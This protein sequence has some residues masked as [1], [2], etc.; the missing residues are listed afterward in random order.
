MKRTCALATAETMA[1]TRDEQHRYGQHYT[2]GDVARLL[3]AFA[4]RAAA[5]LVFDPACGDG[6]LLA[7]AINVKRQLAVQAP[8]EC[9]ARAVLGLDRSAHA[10]ALAAA[11][12]AH[13]WRGDTVHRGPRALV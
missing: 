3:A 5:D 9:L 11:S 7:E 12:S 13:D 10:A 2:P 8:P 6:R 1:K 4:V